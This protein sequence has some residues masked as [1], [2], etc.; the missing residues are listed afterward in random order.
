MSSMP[1]V[2]P[3]TTDEPHLTEMPGADRRAARDEAGLLRRLWRRL[4]VRSSATVRSC[5]HSDRLVVAAEEFERVQQCLNNPQE[6]SEAAIRGAELLRRLPTPKRQKRRVIVPPSIARP[7][8]VAP[9]A[10]A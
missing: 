9:R 2:S 8:S 1:V 3:K 5:G 10:R 7:I 6:P 4:A